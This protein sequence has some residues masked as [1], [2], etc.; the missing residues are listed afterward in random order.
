MDNYHK[1]VLIKEVIDLLQVKPGNKYIDATLGGGGHTFEI[2]RGGATVLGID[3]DIDA[4]DFVNKELETKD[5]QIKTRLVLVKGNFRDIEK[6]AHLNNF[7]NVSGILLDLGVS[8]HQIDTP[9]RGFSFLKDGPLDMRMDRSQ[10]ET[11]ADLVN[12]LSESELADVIYEF[13]EERAARRIARLIVAERAKGAIKT[14][15]QLA[16][17]VVRAVHQKGHWRIHP[18]TKTFQALRIAVNRELE[19]LDQFVA[20][21]IAMLK[22]GGRLAIITFHS[23]EDRMV[24]ET[25]RSLTNENSSPKQFSLLTKKPVVP[26]DAE[27][28]ENP[29]SRSA[30][31]RVIERT[32]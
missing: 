25:F 13:G 15:A 4:L 5:P 2:L 19:G 6:I 10:R 23:L 24:K 14:T 8:S 3:Q 32:A 16:N 31:L 30:K 26:S 1:P 28:S 18:A 7:E 21:A 20:D 12:E 27:Q 9:E 11:A 22:P 29:R 17:L